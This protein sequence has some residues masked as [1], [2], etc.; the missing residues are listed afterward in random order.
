MTVFEPR[1]P[2]EEEHEGLLQEERATSERPMQRERAS[3]EPG[4]PAHRERPIEQERATSER[5]IEEEEIEGLDDIDP[6][7][8]DGGHEQDAWRGVAVEDVDDVTGTLAGFLRK[9]SRKLLGLILHPHVKSLVWAGFLIG[10]RTLCVLAGPLLVEV[11]IDSGIPPL[12]PGGSGDKTT[13]VLVVI[14]SVVVT[15]VNA[16]AFNLFFLVTGRVGQDILFDLRSRVF[17]HF[18]RLSLS[19]HERYTSG[20][21]QSRLTSDVEAIAELLNQGFVNLVNAVLLIGGI[22]VVL[23]VLDWQLALAVLVVFPV[24][25][26]LTWWFRGKA[27]VAY[28]ATREAVAL[29]IVHFT[30]SLAGIRAVHAFRREP[31]NQEIFDELDDRYYRALVSSNRL[32]AVYGTGIMFL[33]RLTTVIVLLYGGERVLEGQMTVG[34][35]AAFLLYLRR[36]FDPMQD[37]SQFYTQFQGAAAALEKLA[38]VLDEAPAVPEPEHPV[39][40]RDPKGALSFDHVHFAYKIVEILPDLDL[41]IPAGQTLALV[42]ATGAGKTTIARLMARFYDPTSGRVSLDGVDLRDLSDEDLRRAVVMVTQDNYLFSGTVADNIRFGRPDA[43]PAQVETA[44]R[45]IGAHEFITALPDGYDTDIQKRG[46]RLSAGQRQLVAFARAFL[47]QPAVLILDEATSSLDIPSERLVQS[48]LRTLLRDRTAVIIAHR[49]ST[50]EI[51][52]RVLVLEDG[53]IVEDGSPADLIAADAGRYHDLHAAWVD[54]L[55]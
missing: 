22:T 25:I 15:I 12:M 31:R 6:T 23:L 32:G 4:T 17:D 38:G 21:V 52:D 45:A 19:F 7:R 41:H 40:L 47:A 27:E 53:C 3:S 28:R 11:A 26:G 51:A 24:A 16:A 49:L 2:L 37:L 9:R 36:F 50:V 33:G 34:V 30:E 46:G 39:A 18:Q 44:A 42:G 14:G 13:I 10:I 8:T 48:A 55:V 5:P 35:L 1:F 54:S 43:T 20:R 29:V